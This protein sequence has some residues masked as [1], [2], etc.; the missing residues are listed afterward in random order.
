MP[1]MDN[2]DLL[3][4]FE[5][6]QEEDA[7]TFR[8]HLERAPEAIIRDGPQTTFSFEHMEDTRDAIFI[9]LMSRL[10]NYWKR[11]SK[12]VIDMEVSVS[13]TLNGETQPL[14]TPLRM[15]LIDGSIRFES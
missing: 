14:R 8:I 7:D 10:D 13:V 11:N 4:L 5:K 3:N 15:N 12:P 1:S 2:E 9:Y 6:L